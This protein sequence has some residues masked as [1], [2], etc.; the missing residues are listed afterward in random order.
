V[1]GLLEEIQNKKSSNSFFSIFVEV[2]KEGRGEGEG[3]GEGGGGGER[4][5]SPV[6]LDGSKMV[7]I[8]DRE[9]SKAKTLGAL[10]FESF[11]LEEGLGL[12][13]VWVWVFRDFSDIQRN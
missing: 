12:L 5:L 13:W 3:E 7:V 9:L 1:K 4:D 11:S 10:G 8:S 6:Y 2:M